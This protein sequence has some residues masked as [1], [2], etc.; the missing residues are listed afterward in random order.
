MRATSEQKAGTGHADEARACVVVSLAA[1]RG[2]KA[3]SSAAENSA[4]A[5][6]FEQPEHSI[7]IRC[8]ADGSYAWSLRGLPAGSRRIAAQALSKVLAVVMED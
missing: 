4:A 3:A 1:V 6:A 8:M 2:R 7:L 5:S